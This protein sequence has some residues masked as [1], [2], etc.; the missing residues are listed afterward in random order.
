MRGSVCISIDLELA[1]GVWDRP[2]RTNARYHALCAAQE[3]TIVAT[4]LELFDRHGI[5]ATWAI[6]GRLLERDD[7][8]AASTPHGE[9]IW[10][11]PDL[12][13]KIATARPAHEIGSHSHAHVYFQESDGDTVRADLLAARAIH[14]RHG[15][16]FRSFVFPRNQVAHLD[17]LREVGLRVFRGDDQG[18][19]VDIKRRLGGTA[20][21]LANLVDKALPIPPAV[22]TPLERGGLTELPGSML[23]LAR[24]GFR[25]IV[26]P[27]AAIAKAR[28]GL[29]AASRYGRVFHL[30]FHPSNFYYETDR[31]F[32]VLDRILGRAAHMRDRGEID[33]R[34]M[35]SFAA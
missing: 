14:E 11:A 31:Q 33:I 29:E 34:T 19:F 15:L 23:L 35:G 24:S 1:W 26:H 22:V 2:S 25:R 32:S 27:A 4:L 20:G 5:G 3:S 7:R 12:V 30:W 16:S 21:R 6:V 10:Y 8:A 18:W 17:T 13:E 28:S 9:R